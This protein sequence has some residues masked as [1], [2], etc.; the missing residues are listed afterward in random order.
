MTQVKRGKEVKHLHTF[1]RTFLTRFRFTRNNTKRSAR[2]K[3]IETFQRETTR[4]KREHHACLQKLLW[5]MGRKKRK[6]NFGKSRSGT[7]EGCSTRSREHRF[8]RRRRKKNRFS[9]E[10]SVRFYR[11]YRPLVMRVVVLS[12]SKQT[13]DRLLRR[14]RDARRVNWWTSSE[15]ERKG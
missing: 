4:N 5:E 6:K 14:W 10:Q 8:E 7:P 11:L 12:A 9:R 1:A 13:V 2:E 15:R 3:D